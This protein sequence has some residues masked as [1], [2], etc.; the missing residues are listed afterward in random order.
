M[1]IEIVSMLVFTSSTLEW[2]GYGFMGLSDQFLPNK[3]VY[4]MMAEILKETKMKVLD[5]CLAIQST[6]LTALTSVNHSSTHLVLNYIDVF[7]V[8]ARI[9]VLSMK[10]D[11]ILSIDSIMV[12][13]N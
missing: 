2:I 10:M 13:T 11:D 12:L 7:D 9:A 6:Q 1:L 4:I 5:M 3:F 8:F